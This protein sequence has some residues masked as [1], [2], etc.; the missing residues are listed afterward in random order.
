MIQ[1]LSWP[2]RALPQIVTAGRF[3]LTDRDFTVTY[4]AATHAIHLYDYEG[5]FRIGGRSLALR[6]GDLTCS[7]AGMET[8]YHL[9]RPGRHWCVHFLPAQGPDAVTIPL[10]Q[11]LSGPLRQRVAETVLRLAGLRSR[12]VDPGGVGAVAAGALLQA[13]LLELALGAGEPTPAARQ[14]RTVAVVARAEAAI[15]RQLASALDVA[16]VATACGLTRPWLARVFHATHGMTL[17]RWH[18]QRRIDHVRILLR[19]TVLP[20]G[21]IAVRLGFSDTQHLNKQFRRI[22]GCSPSAYR[23]WAAPDDA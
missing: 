6:P 17:Q 19:T 1:T 3:Q 15:E 10:H 8:Q 14:S 13:L 16:A 18:L 2:C 23:A 7:P 12:P 4:R 20:V 5:I 9:P 11:R 22:A 21:E